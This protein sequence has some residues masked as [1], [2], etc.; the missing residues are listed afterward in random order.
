MKKTISAVLLGTL[1]AVV[2]TAPALAAGEDIVVF[3]TND[4]H[5]YIDN[6]VEDEAGLTYSKVAALKASEENVILVDAGDHIQGTAYGS[7]DSGATIVQLMNAAG[8]DAATLGNHEF[9]YGMDGCMAT[10]EAAE[11]PYTSCNFLHETTGE[12]VLDSFVIVEAGGKKIAFIGI[13][14]PETFTSSTP[15]YF[16]NEAGEYIYAIASGEDGAELYTAVQTA[17]DEAEAAGADY[18]IALGHLGVDASAS[19]W[20]SR[21]V[22]ANTRG[23]DAFIDGH[24]HT[25][26]PM[27]QV[28]DKAGNAVVLTQTGSYLNTVGKLTIST[29]GEISS[30]LLTGEDL[31]DLAPNAEVKAMEDA[32][33]TEISSKL[34]AVIGYAE[35]TLDNYDSDGTRLVRKQSTNT[36][37][38]AADALYYLFDEMDMDVDVAIINGGGIR[39]KAITGEIAYLTCKEIHTFGNVACLQTVTGQQLLDALEWGAR[40]AAADD[41][42]ENGGFLHVSG[43]KYSIDPSTPSTVQTDDKGVWAGSPTGN[44]RVKNVQVLNNQAGVYEPLDLTASYNLAGYNYTLRDLG[45][46][47]AMFG[48]AVNVLDYVAEDYM[49]LANYVQS[50]PVD[51]ETGL[52]TITADSGYADVN[53]SGRITIPDT[54]GAEQPGEPEANPE[55]APETE[56]VTYVVMPGDSLWRI[57]RSYYGSGAKWNMIYEANRNTVREPDLIYAGQVLEIPAG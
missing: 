30:V 41:S 1:L 27:E 43:L 34:G 57:A 26:I 31:A 29:S 15:A 53:G 36:G 13:T 23:L 2:L 37:D 11:Y 4:V 14:T 55:P 24:S 40:M 52:P 8:Y 9:D 3:Y 54:T 48:G 50:F 38:F 56:S 28:T 16:Q 10:I 18:I 21:E 44:Y 25:T 20:T 49:V 33:V 39:N 19:P 45:D 47:F 6:A 35:V 46:G 32:W 42:V 51:P 5:T 7:M 22:I 12:T 17:I